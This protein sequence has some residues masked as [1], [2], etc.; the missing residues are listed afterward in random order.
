VSFGDR[1]RAFFSGKKNPALKDLEAF[2]AE[3]RG[4][5]GYIEPRTATNSTSLLLVDRDGDHIRA[6][7]RAP[8]DAALFCERR[9]I[10]V[11]DA[12]VV[13]Y[14]SRMR[15]FEKRRRTQY[16]DIVDTEIAEL[17]RRLSEATGNDVPND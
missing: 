3:R 5:E 4:V 17:E 15:D 6:A 12:Q 7:V 11:Y 8:E 14:P 10:P 2:A 9:G 16:G 13:G 1:I